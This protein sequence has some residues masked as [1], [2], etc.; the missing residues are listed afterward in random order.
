MTSGLP[1]FALIVN[2][3]TH[4]PVGTGLFIGNT[5]ILISALV[6]VGKTTGLKGIYGYTYLSFIVDTSKKILGLTQTN[7]PSVPINILLY[8][9]QGLIAGSA[10]GFV[11]YNKYSFGSYSSILPI[12]HKYIKVHPPTFFFI[13][14]F[15]LALITTYFFGFQKGIFL[16]VNAGAFFIS[17]HYILKFLQESKITHPRGVVA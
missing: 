13:L 5:L 12:A 17:F 8:I 4:L 3:K 11:V 14:D 10:I 2:Y 6:I 1:G 7:I 9:F 15:I 16:M